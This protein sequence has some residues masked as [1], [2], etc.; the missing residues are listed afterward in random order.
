MSD[1]CPPDCVCAGCE[2]AVGAAFEAELDRQD[3]IATLRAQLAEARAEV[4]RV[5]RERD[6]A[7][8]TALE[9]FR[10]AMRL[11]GEVWQMQDR[12]EDAE[13]ERD[14]ARA[15]AGREREAR[16]Y[17][18]KALDEIAHRA[19]IAERERDE[20][21]A[22]LAAERARRE[23][24]ER[25]VEAS[26][27]WAGYWREESNSF[28]LMA[29]AQRA[30]A[31]WAEGL[32]ASAMAEGLACADELRARVDKLGALLRKRE[33]VALKY[34]FDLL[35]MHDRVEAIAAEAARWKWLCRLAVAAYVE[36]EGERAHFATYHR[37]AAAKWGEGLDGRDRALRETHAALSAERARA[38]AADAAEA[39]ARGLAATLRALVDSL[40]KCADCDRP[41]TR[42]WHRGADRYCDEH[43][44]PVPEYPRAEALRKAQAALA[45]AEGG[46]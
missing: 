43:G 10:D 46:E 18:A 21:R 9:N 36:A 2:A 27:T 20:A 45:A 13:R 41:A 6:E 37:G 25:D 15:Q 16:E 38:D 35:N 29:L 26:M 30:R 17:L 28:H 7:R 8:A 33:A 14:E 1:P 11:Q 39:R 5:T 12:A 34:G 4:E 23:G 32:A 19:D 44:T 40:P 42:A 31:E 22:E 3:G 24:P